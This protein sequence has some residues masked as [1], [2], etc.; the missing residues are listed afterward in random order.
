MGEREETVSENTFCFIFVM[1]MASSLVK[2]YVCMACLWMNGMVAS[3]G[4]SV[5]EVE[6]T[7][8]G[9]KNARFAFH[10]R[11]VPCTLY[12]AGSEK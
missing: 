1:R 12:L 9:D 6:G 4:G 3:G 11:Y 5:K 10:A 8:I 7:Y 2:W